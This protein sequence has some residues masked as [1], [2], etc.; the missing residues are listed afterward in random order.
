MKRLT[1]LL[2]ALLLP[3]VLFADEKAGSF[4]AAQM[5]FFEKDVLPILQ[6]HC[7]KCHGGEAK[8][9]AGFRLTSRAGVLKGGELGDAVNLQDLKASLLIE[10]I[11]YN[12]DIKMPP[13]GRLKKEQ[14][15]ILTR[16]VTEGLPWSKTDDYGVE[17]EHEDHPKSDSDYWAYQPI[18]RPEIPAVKGA[19]WVKTPIDAFVLARLESEGLSPTRPADKVALIRRAYFDLT[20]LPPSPAD[21]SRLLQDE[22]PQWFEH[23]VD[24]LLESPQYGERWGRH[25]LDLVRYAETHGYERDSTKPEAWRYRDY[26]INAFNQ[27][28]PYDRFLLEQLAGDELPEVTA[29]TLT[30]T[31]YYRLGIWDDEPADRE[32][33]LYDGFDDIVKTTSE[34]V[35]GMTMGCA[36]CHDHKG[37]PLT[38]KEYYSFLAYFRDVV[39][40]GGGNIRFFVTDADRAAQ[41]EAVAAKEDR[42]AAMVAELAAIEVRF[43]K[44]LEEQLG[45]RSRSLQTADLDDLEVR[46]H[47]GRWKE[48]PVFA[49]LRQPKD[50]PLPKGRLAF[51][52]TPGMTGYGFAFKGRLRVP[53]DGDYRFSIRGNDGF[54]LTVAG[55]EVLAHRSHEPRDTSATVALKAGSLS[56]LL[57]AMSESGQPKFSV[58]WSGPGIEER[59]LT[60]DGVTGTEFLAADSRRQGQPWKYT[61]EKPSDDWIQP[62][63][64]ETS[65]KEGPGGFGTRGTPGAVVRTEWNTRDIWLRRW[66]ELKDVPESLSLDLHWDEDTEVYLNGVLVHEVKRFVTDYQRIPLSD[67]AV[68]ALQ[69]GRNVI[70]IH[71]H[72]TGG[73]Q[74]IDAGLVA[75]DSLDLSQALAQHGDKLLGADTERYRT[76]TKQL[77]DSRKERLPE[78]GTP[79]M[80]AMERGRQKTFLLMRG[81][82]HAPGPEVTPTVPAALRTSPPQI[83]ESAPNPEGSGKRTA[84]VKWM[85]SPENPL[86]A[87]VLANRLWHYHFGRGIV[88]T[89]NDFGQLGDGP[90]HSELLD[91]LASELRDGGWTLK[92]MHRL[93]MKSAVYRQSSRPGQPALP[94]AADVDAVDPANTLL[95]RFPMRRLSSEEVRDAML[96]ATGE[97][98]LKA[99]GP[100]IYVPIPAAVLAGQ[101][102]PGAGWGQSSPDE[103]ARRS[104][105]IHLKRSLLVPILEMHDQ[106]DT[107]SS[108]PVRYVTTVPTQSLGMLNGEFT[109]EKAGILARRLEREAGSD[110]AAQVKLAIRLVTARIPDSSEVEQDVKFVQELRRKN[111]LS[112]GDALRMYCLL[113]L[114]TNEAI[115]LD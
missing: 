98:N 32:Q 94:V 20:G 87:R 40:T 5:Q 1:G 17:P 60:D 14:I 35:L 56:F 45:I 80:A 48:L 54:R 108:C 79:I 106:A 50:R 72:Q 65:W 2:L 10:A 26:V 89:A 97:L 83:P 3:A 11:G 43:R 38:Q 91:W 114:N 21:V 77:E 31:G 22:S 107:D 64:S 93:I 99:G 33:A 41:V 71:C 55:R 8:V 67:A 61:T 74:Y 84:L 70:A 101:S 52:T 24:R 16:W 102:R 59:S 75:G 4:T 62:D 13:S 57:E 68:K 110:V 85:V 104:V 28:K 113:L 105:Y 18:R 51:E 82:P 25:W 23:L 58:T 19:E 63:Y 37:D 81:N 112:E 66:F 34:V 42:E 12:G 100:S 69:P 30:A 44:A 86:T 103:A 78:P 111:S 47:R 109:N 36:R 90:T 96:Q 92:R 6:T 76:L 49:D 95:W 27:D 15:D 7:F 115:Y 88:P 46:V 39:P 29:E 53:A 73:G 9:R